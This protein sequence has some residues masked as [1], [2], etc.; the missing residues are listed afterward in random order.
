MSAEEFTIACRAQ[1]EVLKA[2]IGVE[3]HSCCVD[4]GV[5][6]AIAATL[7]LL[8]AKEEKEVV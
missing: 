4:I 2:K 5:E 1:A 8:F 3:E 6:V 7:G